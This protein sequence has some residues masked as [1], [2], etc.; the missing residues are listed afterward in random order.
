M[1][2]KNKKLPNKR[3]KED[4]QK[5]ETKPSHIKI[6]G[7]TSKKRANQ[8]FGLVNFSWLNLTNLKIR[9]KIIMGFIVISILLLI[10]GFLV[11]QSLSQVNEQFTFVIDHDAPVIANAR[12]LEKLI[13]DME[14]GQRGFI[15][16]G[17]TTFLEPFNNG[18][19]DF[20]SLIAEEIVLVSDNPA[21]VQRLRDIAVKM[22]EWQQKAALLEINIS[23]P[24]G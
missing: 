7:V 1:K 24:N 11:L 18:V 9:S 3:A 23:N 13:V 20:E 16:T 2:E 10:L 6:E 15:I 5:K 4:S 14:T 8:A 12:R 22:K 17:D 19:K 21:Q